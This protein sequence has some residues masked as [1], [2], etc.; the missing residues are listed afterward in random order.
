MIIIIQQLKT[1]ISSQKIAHWLI[2]LVFCT[3]SVYVNYG[4]GLQERINQ[5]S[6]LKEYGSYVALYAVHSIFAFLV[7]SILYQKYEFWKAPGFVILLVCSFLIFALRATISQ[8]FDLIED[9]SRE[10]QKR[11]NQFVFNDVFR[12]LCIFIPISLIWLLVDRKTMPLYGLTLKNH[13]PKVYWILLLCML[14]LIAGASCLSDFLSYY[15]RLH[16]LQ[17]Y[18]P[19]TWKLWLFELFYGMDFSSIELFFRGFLVIG[20]AKY[21]GSNSI[22]PMAC[23]YLSIHYGKPMGEAISSFFGGTILGVISYHSG[24]IFGGIMVHAGIAWLMEAGGVIGNY[25]KTLWVD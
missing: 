12:L 6:G 23:F 2:L 5:L 22:L 10:G 1:Y 16:I 25:I 3:I 21:V 19:P 4:L 17:N 8:H 18:N 15:P 7:Y 14:P 20:F 24:S 9:W 13:K 11:I